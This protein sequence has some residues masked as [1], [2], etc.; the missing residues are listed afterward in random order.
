MKDYIE[1]CKEEYEVFKKDFSEEMEKEINDFISKPENVN[2][3]VFAAMDSCL[4]RIVMTRLF[5]LQKRV[6]MIEAA[7]HKHEE[8]FQ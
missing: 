8:V 4:G 5:V 2:A 1:Q 7:S 6:E 3:P